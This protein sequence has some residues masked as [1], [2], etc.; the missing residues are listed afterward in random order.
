MPVLWG[1]SMWI[2]LFYIFFAIAV[3]SAAIAFATLAIAFV[4]RPRSEKNPRSTDHWDIDDRGELVRP[5]YIKPYVK[6]LII[7]PGVGIIFTILQKK[8]YD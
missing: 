2:V 1:D 3:A 6:P 8:D 4:T 5:K 7:Y